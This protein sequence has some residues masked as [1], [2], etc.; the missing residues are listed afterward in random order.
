MTTA[1]PLAWPAGWPRT[2]PHI[3]KDGRQ[4]VTRS[5][6]PGQ[7]WPSARPITFDKA[8]RLLMDELDR[9]KARNPVLSTNVP[10][11]NDGMPR[12]DA[13]ERRLDDPGVA[14]Y[15]TLKGKSMVMAQDAYASLSSNVRSLGLA[16]EHLRGLERHG[17]GTMMERAFNGFAQLTGPEGMLTKRPWWVVMNYSADSDDRADLSPDEIDARFRT[18]AKKRH[19]DTDGGSSAAFIELQE[20]RADAMR[21]LGGE[22]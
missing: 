14:V 2:P 22:P 6:H 19:P 20:A 1:Y 16:I 9:L 21:E 18:L 17:G 11:R 4:F 5:I 8:R 13:A 3:R 7:S 12:A 15:F 10:L